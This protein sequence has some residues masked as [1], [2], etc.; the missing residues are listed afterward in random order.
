M[1]SQ[2]KRQVHRGGFSPN[3]LTAVKGIV[4]PY[5]LKVNKNTVYTVDPSFLH[6]YIALTLPVMIW[7][8]SAYD[9]DG[10]YVQDGDKT[11]TEKWATMNVG[12]TA[13]TEEG[14]Y[15]LYFMWGDV[16]GQKPSGNAF[17]FP[18][19]KYYPADNFNEWSQNSGFYWAN[20]PY[21]DGIFTFEN[22]NT[23]VFTKYTDDK[24]SA[25]GGE[26]DNKIRLDLKDDAAFA[27]WG[28]AWRMPDKDEFD[29]LI[30]STETEKSDI[31]NGVL[32]IKGTSL[33]FPSAGCGEGLDL[34]VEKSYGMYWSS[35][36]YGNDN[37][38]AH[39]LVFYVDTGERPVPM[40]SYYYR[41]AGGSIRPISE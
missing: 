32:T 16:V 36:L 12:A 38:Y 30:T 9:G 13:E 27:N 19:T 1:Q 28:G 33:K 17:S 2:A 14:S 7:D 6:E 11:I 20:C 37:W 15:G 29:N 25:K 39:H 18:A 24:E 5:A 31:S 34:F 4:E 22:W 35:S 10:G 8:D 40:L 41:Y 23:A 26:P 3:F 21:T